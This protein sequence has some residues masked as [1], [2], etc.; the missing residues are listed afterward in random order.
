MDK[1]G[2]QRKKKNE[3]RKMRREET[4]KRNYEK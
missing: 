3:K 1:E 2:R 4:G